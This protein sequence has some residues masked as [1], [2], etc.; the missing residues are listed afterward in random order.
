M[1]IALVSRSFFP[2]VVGG[3]ERFT[4]NLA[5]H[6]QALGAQVDLLTAA[7]PGRPPDGPWP[8]RVAEFPWPKSRLYAWSYLLFI[9][10]AA[11][12]VAAGRYDA[13]YWNGFAVR[14]VPGIPAVL[15]P[16]GLEPFK[17]HRWRPR[18]TS[19]PLLWNMRREIGRIDRVISEGG[20]LTS[21]VMRFLGVPRERIVE[22]P[23]AVDLDYVDR[24]LAAARAEAPLASEGA[25]RL[26]YVGRLTANKG[27]NVLLQALQDRPLPMGAEVVLVGTGPEVSRLQALA[28]GLPVRFVGEVPE[29]DLFAWYASADAFVFPTRY[30]GMPTVVLEA[31]AAGLPIIASDIGAVPTMVSSENGWLVPA[32]DAAAL[33]AALRELAKASEARRRS[34][35]EASRRI[36]EGRFTWATMARTT[37]DLLSWLAAKGSRLMPARE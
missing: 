36:V 1:R 14:G 29:S 19:L 30:E 24:R 34:L 7:Q 13:V 12:H 17:E 15:N 2:R 28:E 16:Q 6:L 23:N 22:I 25:L 18:L 37:L 33:A 11:Q 8:F 20:H 5:A 3:M 9:G 4:T 35:G 21:E 26:L 31:M 10:A 27:V 32:G